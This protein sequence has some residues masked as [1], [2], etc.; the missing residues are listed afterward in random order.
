[1]GPES[2]SHKVTITPSRWHMRRSL[3]P[4]ERSLTRPEAGG[5]L[6]QTVPTNTSPTFSQWV[7]PLPVSAPQLAQQGQALLVPPSRRG[8]IPT[9]RSGSAQQLQAARTAPGMLLRAELVQG[10]GPPLLRIR[11]IALLE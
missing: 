7:F 1:M 5:F 10:L 6:S 8:P 3:Q 4:V 11:H 9:P 2:S